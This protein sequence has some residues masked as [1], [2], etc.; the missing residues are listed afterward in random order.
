MI[1]DGY[2]RVFALKGG[3]RKWFR[4]QYPVEVK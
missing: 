1:A 3:W 2:Q 4:D